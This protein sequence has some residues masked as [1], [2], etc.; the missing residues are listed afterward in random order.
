MIFPRGRRV[1]LPAPHF[2]VVRAFLTTSKVQKLGA[3]RANEAEVLRRDFSVQTQ[4]DRLIS[5]MATTTQKINWTAVAPATDG[6]VIF[7]S[8]GREGYFAALESMTQEQAVDVFVAGYNFTSDEEGLDSQ[9]NPETREQAEAR[10]R[11]QIEVEIFA[12]KAD[13]DNA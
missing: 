1:R 12:S 2:S 13:A 9:G 3:V 8:D 4:A 11:N 5:V 6:R 10:L 7:I